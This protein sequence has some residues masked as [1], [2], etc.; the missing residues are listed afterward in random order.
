MLALGIRYLTGYAVATDVADRER[1]EWPPHP[2][3]VFMALAA[4][5]FETGEDAD[6]RSALEW[7]EQQGAPEIKTPE[8]L[9]REVVTHYVPVN[10]PSLPEQVRTTAKPGTIKAGLAVLPSHRPRQPRTFPRV[11]PDTDLVYLLWPVASPSPDCR[12]ALDRLCGKVVRIGHSSSLAQMWVEDSLPEPTHIPDPSG[13]LRLR[14]V[15]EGTLA[16]LRSQFNAMAIA[17]YAELSDRFAS[18]MGPAKRAIKREF[19]ARF[20][21]G[22]PAS[23]RPVV[24]L[25]QGYREINGR[26]DRIEPASGAFS[27]DLLV[28]ALQDGPVVGLETTWQ[29]LTALRD[30]ILSRCDPTPEWVS[31]HRADGSPS[32]Q[33][34]LALLP[35]A[36]VGHPHADGHLLGVA[37]AFPQGVTT[38]QR[39]AA[40]RGLLYDA[41]GLPKSIELRLGAVGTWY[42]SREQRDAPPLALQ[43]STW[44]GPSCSW[45]T[46]TPIVLDRHPKADYREDRPRWL[47]EVRAGI[48]ESCRRQGLPE[49]VQVEVDKTCW[50]RGAPGALPGKGGFP[51]APAKP[52]SPARQQIHAWLRF[53]QQVEGP[54]LL[55]AGR[56]RG[57]G[58]CK[59]W[60]GGSP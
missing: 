35:L 5:Y 54:L 38:R 12:S 56:Y 33:V 24:G 11:R 6:E 22:E 31:G 16:Y 18:A 20:P 23:R 49:P 39:G 58:L 48:V 52:G 50:H 2:A 17:E 60:Q 30:T 25:W 32:Q 45:A 47:Q 43:E 44:N 1:A 55:G 53:E 26:D 29:L 59:P 15:S 9:P 4:A 8:A 57:Y 37:L 19:D 46:V 13:G 27:R 28:L 36:F 14:V 41:D 3:R 10:D 34:H 40:L 42:L 21:D 51:L 7:L